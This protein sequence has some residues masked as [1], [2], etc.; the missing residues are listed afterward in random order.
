MNQ[1]STQPGLPSLAVCERARQSRDSR[2]DGRFF[3][4][5]L[6]T[7]IYCRPIC[8]AR[9]SARENVRFYATAA[10]AQEAGFRPCLRCRPETAPG[11]AAWRG[12]SAVVTRALRLIEQGA[13]DDGSVAELAARVGLSTRHLDRLFVAHVGASPLAIAN[14]RRLHF[15]KRMIDETRLPFGDIAIAAG[16]GSVRQFN[17]LIRR[18][19]QRSPRDLRRLRNSHGR[20]TGNGTV[21]LRLAARPPFDGASV[22]EWLGPR[23]I[24]GVEQVSGGCYERHLAD[25]ALLRACPDAEGVRLQISGVPA[26]GLLDV[27]TRARRL[28]DLECEPRAV[29]EMLSQDRALRPLLKT[30]PGLRIPGSW[31]P[32][33]L[34]VRCVLGQQVSVAA[35]NTLATRLSEQFNKGHG[36]PDAATLAELPVERIGLPRSRATALRNLSMEMAAGR[37]DFDSPERLREQLLSIRGIGPWTAEYICLRAASDPDAFP[38]GDLALQNVMTKRMFGSRGG[39]LRERDFHE[40]AEAWRPWRGYVALLMWQGLARAGKSSGG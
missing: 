9:S 1:Y 36:F 28:F 39:N 10:A 14:T 8:P 2:Y 17:D 15:A 12:T 35:A 6:T 32:F 34:A 11:S 4:A 31:D 22:L 3:I 24:P 5:V 37:L 18:T 30:F 33:E 27:V 21:E 7:G 26:S 40:R 23:A 20:D 16:F 38:A 19:W 25:G 13:L 29:R